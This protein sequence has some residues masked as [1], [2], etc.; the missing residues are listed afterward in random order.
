MPLSCLPPASRPRP[1]L[2]PTLALICALAGTAAF[3]TEPFAFDPVAELRQALRTPIA[4]PSFR[5][6]EL[7]QRRQTLN[8]CA[9]L[10]C[11][12]PDLREA[13]LLQEWRAETA[14]EYVGLVDQAAHAAIAR[15]FEQAVLDILRQGDPAG[16]LA[17]VNMLAET[18]PLL[19]DTPIP[20]WS[21]RGFTPIL[22]ELAQGQTED[23]AEA[24]ARALSRINADPILAAPALAQLARSPEVRRRRA[25]AGGLAGFV[26]AAGQ[27]LYRRP[28]TPGQTSRVEVLLLC[29][30]AIPAA[31][32][33]LGDADAEVRGLS[34]EALRQ[35]VAVV[36]KL[37]SDPALAGPEQSPKQEHAQLMALARALQ[38]QT[39]GLS[40]AL[41][42]PA[43]EVRLRAHQTL[44][45]IAA[46]CTHL[47]GRDGGT[48][49]GGPSAGAVQRT[50]LANQGGAAEAVPGA[51]VRAAE[52]LRQRLHAALPS[53]VAGVADPDVRVRRA[54]IEALEVLGPDAAPAA[55]ALVRALADPDVFVRWAAART[56][57]KMAPA[58]AALAVPG[59][60]ERLRDLDLDVRL[61]AAAAL[62]QYGPA[63]QP[64]LPGLIEAVQQRDPAVRL[65]ALE[66]LAGIGITA[67][68]AIPAIAAALQTPDARVRRAAAQLLGRFGPLAL[69]VRDGLRPA[70]QDGDAEVR[71]AASNAL[72]HIGPPPAQPAAVVQAAA[73]Q[74]A[75]LP[76]TT[77]PAPVI[78]RAAHVV[79]A[80][81]P[82]VPAPAATAPAALPPLWRPPQ[83]SSRV[84]APPPVRILAPTIWHAAPATSPPQLAQVP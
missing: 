48:A 77:S 23:L 32:A 76:G 56:L 57:G 19:R 69:A 64:A 28:G 7:Q 70:M 2:R 79:P 26:Q 75:P 73:Y 36:R 1:L 61:A 10:L 33:G 82:P 68:P 30:L 66:A 20:G 13:L 3:G 74:P 55:P 4:D 14:Q 24:A 62:K 42:D 43:A 67:Q 80:P 9:A 5:S 50:G 41:Q 16:R 84:P 40:A 47:E 18:G 49:L 25:G 53:L 12:A 46:L 72:L 22:A 54:A 51:A 45:E 35:S 52:P 58:P 60:E 78:W 71:Q 31:C 83:S 6:P 15:R 38:D 63:A 34:I 21:M 27:G 65:A 44:E 37:I 39:A 29:R 59:L 8:R 81:A 11:R 17:A